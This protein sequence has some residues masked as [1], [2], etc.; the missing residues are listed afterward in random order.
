MVVAADCTLQRRRMRHARR[1]APAPPARC[2]TARPSPQPLRG[3]IAAGS[4]T[5][6]TSP[7]ASWSATNHDGASGQRTDADDVLRAGLSAAD[8]TAARHEAAIDHDLPPVGQPR[9][10]EHEIAGALD[11]V[12]QRRAAGVDQRVAAVEKLR[13]QPA[14]GGTPNCPASGPASPTGGGSAAGAPFSRRSSVAIRASFQA[15]RSSCQVPSPSSTARPPARTTPGISRPPRRAPRSSL[16]GSARIEPAFG[17]LV[18]VLQR[19]H[20]ALHRPQRQQR[21]RQDQRQPQQR[22]HPERR[23]DT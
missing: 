11:V 15:L 8:R 4:R 5:Y 12:A 20:Q 18:V 22:V 1:A 14:R 21:R 17:G 3:A 7:A 19:D 6:Q 10:A 2:R 13:A 23:L 9:R 16:H